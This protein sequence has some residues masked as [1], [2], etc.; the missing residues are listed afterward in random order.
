MANKQGNYTRKQWKKEGGQTLTPISAG[1]I[2]GKVAN[3]VKNRKRT[4]RRRG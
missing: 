4:Q 3:W 1:N 2:G